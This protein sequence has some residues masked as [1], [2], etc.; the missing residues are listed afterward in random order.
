MQ[1][2]TQ[3]NDTVL[4]QRMQTSTKNRETIRVYDYYSLC[5][6][7]AI[8]YRIFIRYICRNIQTWNCLHNFGKF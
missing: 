3:S 8:V 6:I 1:K 7:Y 2:V 5:T 4:R